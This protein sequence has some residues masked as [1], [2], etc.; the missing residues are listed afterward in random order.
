MDVK[1]IVTAALVFALTGGSALAA[2]RPVLFGDGSV[3]GP[4]TLGADEGLRLCHA[5]SLGDGSVRGT[6]VI[7]RLAGDGSV[8]PVAIQ[9][10]VAEP[11]KGGC[12]DLA[13]IKFFD[14]ALSSNAFEAQSVSLY[15][16]LIG[17]RGPNRRAADLVSSVQRFVLL[18]DGRVTFGNLLPAVQRPNLLLPALP[19]P[20]TGD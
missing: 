3:F 18:E 2:D 10:I 4:V 19:D 7:Y 12:M 5:A 17:L 14:N 13:A 1:R 20:Q 6:W 9:R 11:D 8:K 15:A 16:I